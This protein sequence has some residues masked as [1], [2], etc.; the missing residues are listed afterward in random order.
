M[1]QVV[2]L[3][4]SEDRSAAGCASG[5]LLSVGAVAGGAAGIL[6]APVTGPVGPLATVAAAGIAG[7]VG[8]AAAEC[9]GR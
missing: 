6:S 8:A 7:S 9:S 5:V 1:D 3:S 4:G 2:V